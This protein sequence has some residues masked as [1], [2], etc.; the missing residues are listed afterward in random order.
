VKRFVSSGWFPLLAILDRLR[1]A[2]KR[3]VSSG[4]F[5]LVTILGGGRL[6]EYRTAPWPSSVIPVPYTMIYGIG[7]VACALRST[8]WGLVAS[9][10]WYV[11]VTR[12]VTIGQIAR[13]ALHV[14]IPWLIGRYAARSCADAR[15]IAELMG[16]LAGAVPHRLNN[17]LMVAIGQ[18]DEV[19]SCMPPD[20]YHYLCL[21]EAKQAAEQAAQIVANIRSHARSGMIDPELLRTTEWMRQMSE[22]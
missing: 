21:T 11:A 13:L 10:S 16:V 2:W 19:R 8:F 5:P 15:L 18:C 14:S 9:L 7:V 17:L 6:F 1:P 4:W 3:I 20:S 12:S 22:E